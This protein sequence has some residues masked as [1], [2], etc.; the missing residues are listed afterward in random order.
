MNMAETKN[1]TQIKS[2]YIVDVVL[3]FCFDAQS[4]VG[5]SLQNSTFD[6]YEYLTKFPNKYNRTKN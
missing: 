5:L 1:R 2:T 3:F 4:L 6:E